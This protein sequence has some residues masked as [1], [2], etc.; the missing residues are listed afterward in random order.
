MVDFLAV[1]ASL[2]FVAVVA[3][4]GLDFGKDPKELKMTDEDL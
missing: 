1:T 3:W 2:V 4:V